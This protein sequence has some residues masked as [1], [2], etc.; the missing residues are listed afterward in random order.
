MPGCGLLAR[1]R[2]N[3]M[4]IRTIEG[5]L[6]AHDGRPSTAV[7]VDR[8]AAGEGKLRHKNRGVATKRGGN[9]PEPIPRSLARVRVAF[10]GT[11]GRHAGA[12]SVVAEGVSGLPSYVNMYVY[13]PDKVAAKPPI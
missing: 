7:S 6:D 4:V 2:H 3:V 9:E 8:F 11:A 1:R 12:R 13:V 5:K 10:R